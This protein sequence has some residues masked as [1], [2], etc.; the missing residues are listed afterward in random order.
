MAK[1]SLILTKKD[2]QPILVD[3]DP[4]TFQELDEKTRKFSS[5]KQLIEALIAK[6]ALPYNKGIDGSWNV[7]IV[8]VT[9]NKRKKNEINKPKYKIVETDYRP[10]YKEQYN[11]IKDDPIFEQ[12]KEFADQIDT[13]YNYYADKEVYHDEETNTDKIKWYLPSDDDKRKSVMEAMKNITISGKRLRGLRNPQFYKF[14]KKY[15]I[16]NIYKSKEIENPENGDKYKIRDK[17]EFVGIDVFDS[18]VNN[19]AKE[20]R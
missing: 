2:E 4:V 17:I 12:I 6:R 9:M 16:D 20:V 1:Y 5:R 18:L 10:L 3:I 19:K 14:A 7:E 13:I 11:T 8:K 15:F